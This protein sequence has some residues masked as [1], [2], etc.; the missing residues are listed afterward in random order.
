[1]GTLS[2]WQS[3]LGFDQ[4]LRQLQRSGKHAEA[5]VFCTGTNKGQ[6]HWALTQ[7]DDALKQTLEINQQAFDSAVDQ[8]LKDMDGFEIIT[9]IVAVA[10]ALLTLFGLRPRLKEYS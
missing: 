1:M 3:Y 6:L 10:I 8:G 7:F 2:Q 4:Q 5:I 9:P